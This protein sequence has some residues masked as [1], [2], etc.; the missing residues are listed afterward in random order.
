MAQPST[1]IPTH[2]GGTAVIARADIALH[3]A[4]AVNPE[5]ARV[6]ADRWPL[7][8]DVRKP[9]DRSIEKELSSFIRV[10]TTLGPTMIAMSLAMVLLSWPD[11]WLAW[12]VCVLALLFGVFTLR[13]TRMARRALDLV[14]HGRPEAC[15]VEIRKESGDDRDYVMGTVYRESEGKWDMSF[16]PP[17][18]NVDPILLKTLCAQVYF[19]PE[20]EYPLVVVTD[21]GHLW[22]E[23]VP[24]KVNPSAT[25]G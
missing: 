17:L 1:P 12:L 15:V 4:A 2:Y 11:R 13:H 9:M 6:N 8:R 18:W 24:T 5:R 22:A 21:G 25:S 19:E 16:A 20:T 10:W 7:R 23:R 3:P 14:R